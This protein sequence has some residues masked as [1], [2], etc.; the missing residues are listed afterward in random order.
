MTISFSRGVYMSTTKVRKNLDPIKSI[1]KGREGS[2]QINKL[3]CYFTMET[4]KS[5]VVIV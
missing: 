3:N 5:R 4:K 2:T 1:L